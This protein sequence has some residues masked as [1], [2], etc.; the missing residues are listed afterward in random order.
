LLFTRFLHSS[1]TK[2][3]FASYR[4]SASDRL[5]LPNAGAP[6]I[7]WSHCPCVTL[8]KQLTDALATLNGICGPLSFVERTR[9]L[10]DDVCNIVDTVNANVVQEGP[11]VTSR[12]D[13]SA[14]ASLERA[15]SEGRQ[16]P[17]E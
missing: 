5:V 15:G 2:E 3:I 14:A 6:L 7:A 17:G 13:V 8:A 11:R 1:I 9:V 12:L 10:F 4:G 16:T